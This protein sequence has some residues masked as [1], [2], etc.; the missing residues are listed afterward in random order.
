MQE[1]RSSILPQEPA[2]VP[3]SPGGGDGGNTGDAPGDFVV[4]V[5][6][7]TS[8]AFQSI[9]QTLFPSSDHRFH[10]LLGSLIVNS[11]IA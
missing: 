1:S 8:S 7:F 11:F 4:Y 3:G 9:C 6:L 5:A 2:L 10:E